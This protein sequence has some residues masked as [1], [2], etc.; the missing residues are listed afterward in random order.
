L[1]QSW[2]GFGVSKQLRV[3]SCQWSVA[4]G[5]WSVTNIVSD[6]GFYVSRQEPVFMGDRILLIFVNFLL[7][8]VSLTSYFLLFL[9]GAEIERGRI[10]A[11]AQ[12]GWRGTIL[13]HMSQMR[14]ALGAADFGPHHAVFRIAVLGHAAALHWLVEA[15]P[16]RA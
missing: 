11:V 8:I 9:S 6:L 10:H 1:Q 7:T 2:G 5:Q 13:K 15:R 3:A 4:S 14:V 12:P 16:A